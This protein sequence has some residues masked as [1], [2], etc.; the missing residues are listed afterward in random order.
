MEWTPG[1]VSPDIEDRRD[2]GGGGGGFGFGN[3]G[4]LHLGI[5]GTLV[6]LALSFIFRTNLLSIFVGPSASTQPAHRVSDSNT[7]GEQ[8]EVEFVSFVLD[9]V[10][11]TWERLLPASGTPYHHAKLVLFRDYTSSGCGTAQ[12]ATGPFYCP[13]DE[14]VYIDLAFFEEL[15]DRFGA[16]GEFA[17]AYVIAHELGHHVQK[18]QGIEPRVRRLQQRDPGQTDHLSV[19]LELQADCYAGIWGHSTEQR[20]IIDQADIGDG[21]RAA[22]S[23]GDDR[24]QRMSTGHV[25]PETFTH[26]SASQRMNWFRRGLDTGDTAACNTFAQ[27]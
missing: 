16:P 20:K 4:G 1:G 24:L 23:V 11:R 3:F 21:L 2:E 25:S 18:L 8:R 12:S 26:G 9:D 17:Q 27:Q 10:Q 15:R 6:L 7:A 22:A 14:K 13:E 19:E 5:G